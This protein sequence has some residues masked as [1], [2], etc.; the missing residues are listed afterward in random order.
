MFAINMATMEHAAV[1]KIID[2]KSKI[3]E[4]IKDYDF[5]HFTIEIELDEETCELAKE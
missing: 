2:T 1:T 5:Q 3:K 4:Y